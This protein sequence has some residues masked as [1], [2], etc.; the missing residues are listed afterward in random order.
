MYPICVECLQ[1]A[2]YTDWVH[3]RVI[4]PTILAPTFMYP[5]CVECLQS[6]F[7]TD[8][9]HFE[10][11]LFHLSLL[12]LLCT[13][14]VQN[15]CSQHSTQIGYRRQ[16]RKMPKSLSVKNIPNLCRKLAYT[17]MQAFY[18]DWVYKVFWHFLKMY[19]ICVECLHIGICKHS[20]QIG[21]IRLTP[22]P[23]LHKLG[24]FSKMCPI[25]VE[26]LRIIQKDCLEKK[27]VLY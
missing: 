14:F 16:F 24:T 3:L 8:W 17:Y 7:Y 5:I 4:V 2:F 20:T 11:S 18:T 10:E 19:P 27:C 13:Q 22:I 21:Y 25:C 15:A 23:F 1:T 12:Q 26:C 6:E 9:V